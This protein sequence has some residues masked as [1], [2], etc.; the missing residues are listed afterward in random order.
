[1]LHRAGGVLILPGG[2]GIVV[3][4]APTMSNT[5]WIDQDRALETIASLSREPSTVELAGLYEDFREK[6]R[7]TLRGAVPCDLIDAYL[8]ELDHAL[9]ERPDVLI[10]FGRDVL[11]I[12]GWDIR[13][14][15][16]KIL[17]T[18]VKLPAALNM[19]F[20]PA[21]SRF[22]AGIFAEAPLAFQ[23]LHFEVGSTQAVHQDTAYVVV[24]EPTRLIAAWIALEDIR[25]GSG[26]LVYYPGSHRFE[27][28][29]YGDA[30]LH[31]IPETDGG[32]KHD[33]HLQWIHDEAKR[34]EIEL[35]HFLPR[36]GD[37]LMWHSNLAH[38]GGKIE[39]ASL[40]R[41]SLV[42]HYCPATCTPHFFRFVGPERRVKKWVPQGGYVSSFY[43]TLEND[44]A[45][46]LRGSS[47]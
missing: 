11:P 19:I 45:W 43:Y 46:S 40:T 38:G 44:P 15:L 2:T 35:E 14:P 47:S 3:K 32:E 6:G 27:S 1:V 8:A 29:L 18:H 26:E 25:P 16:T 4:A 28:Y 22:L 9:A 7:C 17:D 36:K 30:R 13:K 39:D 33:R 21:I 23:S 5:L 31:W 24:D 34:R 42:L 37:V 10:S 41:R 12:V 20:A